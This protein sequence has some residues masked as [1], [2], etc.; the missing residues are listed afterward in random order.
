MKSKT[1]VPAL[2][3]VAV[4]ALGAAG[5]ARAQ[6][7]NVFWSIGMSAPGMHVGVSNA[8]A[9]MMPPVVYPAPPVYMPQ[10][11]VVVAPR[12]VFYPA[13]PVAWGYGGYG[14]REYR[15]HEGWRG[16]GWR[17]EERFEHERY[18]HE[19]YEH[20]RAGNWE[21]RGEAR[22]SGRGEGYGEGHRH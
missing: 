1:S 15:E 17:G 12:P 5:A 19:R 2:I 3:C 7:A 21:G 11:A 20:G 6:D 9:V 10:H 18:E 8:P 22:F 14:H 16:Y 4:L 13:V